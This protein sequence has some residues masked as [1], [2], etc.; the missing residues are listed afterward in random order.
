[1]SNYSI[2]KVESRRSGRFLRDI[3][4]KKVLMIKTRLGNAWNASFPV[5]TQCIL[6]DRFNLNI[7]CYFRKI[8]CLLK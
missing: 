8:A 6:E 1:M 4:E 2:W 5:C 7:M 3:A